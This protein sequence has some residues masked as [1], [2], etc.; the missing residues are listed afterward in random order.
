MSILAELKNRFAPVLRDL[1]DDAPHVPELLD[2]IRPAQDPKFGDYQA[3]FAMPLKARLN[4]PPREIAQEAVDRVDV[5]DICEPPEIAGPGF[6]NLR[7]KD[8]WLVDRLGGALGDE[9]LGIET[10]GS[11]RTFVVDYSA[12][13]VAKPM[14]VG[15][16][17]S[18]VIGDSI[19]RT[20]RFL[21]HR[22]V[23]DNHI[24]DWGTQFGM[25]IYGY[26]H[27][28]DAK[29]YEEDAVTELARLYK[30]V[31]K[32]LDYWDGK[33]KLPAGDQK[34]AEL[35]TAV[36]TVKQKVEDAAGDK[37]AEKKAGKELRRAEAQLA[38]AKKGQAELVEKIEDF[39]SSPQQLALAT[40][41]AEIGQ[42]VLEETAKLHA[43][44][45]ENIELWKTFMP[46]CRE[47]IERVYG[48]LDIKF[49]Y[50]Y[51]ESFYHDRLAPVVEAFK[52]EGLAEESDGAQ[53][54][55]FDEFDTPM[56]I[57][58]RDGAFLYATTDL[59]TIQY[60]LE[61]WQPDAILYVVDHRQ[62]EH[63]GKLFAA[64][65]Q[66]LADDEQFKD[67]E[68]THVKFGTVLGED[69]RP[70]KTRAG[71]TVGLEGLLDEAVARALKV[72]S[73]N[74]DRKPEGAEF[75]DDDRQTIS[76][77][78]GI[79]ALKYAD[80]SQNRESDYVFSYDKMLALNGNTATYMQYAY[81]RVRN[82]FAK[83]NVDIQSIKGVD[84][85]VALGEPAERALTLELLKFADALESVVSDY[86]PNQLTSYLFDLADRYST[87]YQNCPVLKAD[88]EA[89][90]NSRLLL[91]DLTARTLK[92]GLA[93]LGISVIE[94]M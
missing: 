84:A 2:M 17:R 69:G 79:A 73:E 46:A 18:T 64:A 66:W 62:S 22:V 58:K 72:V 16:I 74:D 21:G 32:I 19:C 13:N 8:T 24:G 88:T 40:E 45:P 51:G 34:I 71:D 44:D 37:K 39:E 82:I 90:R 53:C 52:T 86:R 85:A 50:E 87:F 92:Q 77:T 23:S 31:R 25:I 68:L 29:A 81:A 49:D 89:Q 78:V 10:V 20:L 75:S 57:Q 55:F 56:I 26:K 65:R 27:F 59:A 11:P 60:R 43:D 36:A 1:T 3:N 6:I 91:C 5:S 28:L 83:G 67:L 61:T 70:F 47:E 35:E 94:K 15:H 76:E 41:H 33:Q 4:R 42:F 54:V 9:R 14:H 7:I 48:R 93:L 80:L 30:L 12:P 38:D 63:F